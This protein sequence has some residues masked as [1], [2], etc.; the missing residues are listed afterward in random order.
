MDFMKQ[1]LYDLFLAYENAKRNKR[2]TSSVMEFEYDFESQLIQLAQDL[3]DRTYT[4]STSTYFIHQDR[5][6]REIFAAHFR[7]RIVHHLRYRYVYPYIDPYFIHD[8]YS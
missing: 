4:I 7:D 5:V 8:S 1:L 2:S 6:V 3:Y